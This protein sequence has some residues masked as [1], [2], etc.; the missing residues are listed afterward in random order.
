MATALKFVGEQP[1]ARGR[2]AEHGE[3]DM[4]VEPERPRLDVDLGHAGFA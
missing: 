1:G 2:I 3:V 4:V